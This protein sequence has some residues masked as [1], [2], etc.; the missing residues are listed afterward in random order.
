MQEQLKKI[1]CTIVNYHDQ[2]MWRTLEQHPFTRLGKL[3]RAQSV[4]VDNSFH[5]GF[6]FF[7]DVFASLDMVNLYDVFL[8]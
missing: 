4:K 7:V 6:V 2:T 1:E 5:L 3:A 8:K